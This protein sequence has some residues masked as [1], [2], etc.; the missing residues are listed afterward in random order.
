MSRRTPLL[1]FLAIL[2]AAVQL[3]SPGFS[4]IA[5]G[6]QSSDS[7]SAPQT[8]IEATTSESCPVVHSP[9]CALC[10]YLTHQAG[11]ASF[12]TE[13]RLLGTERQ[14]LGVDCIAERSA[15]VALP[16]GRAPPAI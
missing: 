15:A 16:H 12:G 7:A 6:K 5:D 14:E 11:A 2:W 10:R 3:A 8:H 9:D 13:W 1:R 4:A